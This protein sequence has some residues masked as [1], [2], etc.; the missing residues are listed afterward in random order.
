MITETNIPALLRLI[1]NN[2]LSKAFDLRHFVQPC[3]TFGCLI[4]ND[5]L[6]THE[7]SLA[8]L[9]FDF[10]HTNFWEFS[11]CQYKTSHWVSFWLFNTHDFFKGPWGI[12][13]SKSWFGEQRNCTDRQAAL[14]RVRKFVYYVLHKRE[15]LYDDS[16]CIRET[17]RR[18]EGDQHV[19]Q[20]VQQKVRSISREMQ[21]V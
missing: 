4:G 7:P 5:W 12:R 11:R 21:V 18:S 16:G 20:Q 17:A 3:G 9:E 2:E 19:L 6:A 14:N 13:L 10:R 8:G 1:K 15:L